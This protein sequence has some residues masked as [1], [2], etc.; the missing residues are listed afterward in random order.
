MQNKFFFHVLGGLT[1]KNDRD[2][3]I[4]LSSR[5]AEALLIYLI[6]SEKASCER[7]ELATLFWED[8]P[9]RQAL[10]NLRVTLSNIKKEW[11]DILEVSR[12]KVS[13]NPENQISVDGLELV[14]TLGMG[15]GLEPTREILSLAKAQEITKSLSL[16]R[17]DFLKGFY[18]RDA[19]AF[20]DWVAYNRES[21]KTAVIAAF[22][23]LILTY[24]QNGRNSEGI[25]A[26]NQLLH[27]DPF[28][29]AAYQSLIKL[30]AADGQ[31]DASI[32]TFAKYKGLME[33][34]LGI[35]PDKDIVQI[36]DL[37]KKA[38]YL[39]EQIKSAGKRHANLPIPNNIPVQVT[40]F[41]GR[42]KELEQLRGHLSNPQLRLITMIGQGGTGK[43]R[44]AIEAA[45]Q[46]IQRF[47][48]GVWFVPLEGVATPNLVLPEIFKILKISF[49][50]KTQA[51]T[52]LAEY[53][54]GHRMLLVLDNFE[55]VLEASPLISEVINRT[56]NSKFIVTS[57]EITGLPEEISMTIEGLP[58]T[59][60]NDLQKSKDDSARVE[61]IS[62][63]AMLFIDRVKRIDPNYVVDQKDMK[64]I[65]GIIELVSGLPLGIELAAAGIKRYSLKKL[66]EL[67]SA[68]TSFLK[69]DQPEMPERQRSLTAVFNAFWKQ[70]SKDERIIMSRLA[71]FQGVV[72]QT[73]AQKVASASPFFLGNLVSRG[74][75]QRRIPQ[76]YI[77][78]SMH[79]RFAYEKLK[80]N[81]KEFETVHGKYRYYFFSYAKNL[82]RDIRDNPQKELLDE[83]EFENENIRAAISFTIQL[84]DEQKA[85][86]FCELMMPFW[87]IR[88]YYEEG[89]HWLNQTFELNTNANL[90]MK[91]AVLCAAAKLVTVLGDYDQAVEYSNRSLKLATDLGDQHGVA[92]ALNSLGA[93]IASSGDVKRAEIYFAKSLEIYRNLRVQQA[94]AGTLVHI[95]DMETH[96]KNLIQARILLD[97]ALI[98]F[99][100]VGDTLGIVH[101]LQ[102]YAKIHMLKNQLTAA[103]G[104]LLES[105]EIAWRLQARDELVN[106]YLLLAE[107]HSDKSEN[108]NAVGLLALVDELSKRYKLSL[109]A[110]DR[111]D[112]RKIKDRQLKEL[113][114]EKFDELWLKG[115][116]ISESQIIS[117]Y[118]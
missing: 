49:P 75:L 60:Q 116:T 77:V 5:K 58:L 43:T 3:I 63:A 103:Y 82:E 31:R 16:Y 106:N 88:G 9:E 113:K 71:V 15:S 11:G 30:Y 42:A 53:L 115:K 117:K 74:L 94:I 40:S 68:D 20:E 66:R 114:R 23:I 45:R 105:M 100:T 56:E 46:N 10:T 72:T 19:L 38:D 101:V 96:N 99:R 37:I 61:T 7:E 12:R 4:N 90:V 110:D 89:Y 69:S 52:K 86:E 97:E 78:H 2:E 18:I 1:I 91:S 112:F 29:D 51:T 22:Q 24:F 25:E 39:P 28:N 95:A 48:E 13:L 57:R 87:K 81:A 76:G 64:V 36:I 54:N 85:M 93:S 111:A 21:I 41:V 35:E 17:G 55:Q 102:S 80:E 98:I 79:R 14:K 70:L 50:E 67:I 92:R 34:E 109:K 26:A 73:S 8:M 108:E 44:L 104:Q 33:S 83:I 62:P 118:L 27:I 84:K 65:S 47:P 32:S 59:P 6:Y 107:Y